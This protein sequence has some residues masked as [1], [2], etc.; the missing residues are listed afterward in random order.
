[1]IPQG[2]QHQEATLAAAEKSH[3]CCCTQHQAES[4]HS[5]QRATDLSGW[6]RKPPP[7]ELSCSGREGNSFT[8]KT[9][10][11]AS[12]NPNN[13]YAF[14]R[15]DLQKDRTN[16]LN[17]KMHGWKHHLSMTFHSVNTGQRAWEGLTLRPHQ[18]PLMDSSHFAFQHFFASLLSAECLGPAPELPHW[19]SWKHKE[20]KRDHLLFFHYS[21]SSPFSFQC[22]FSYCPISLQWQPPKNSINCVSPYLPLSHCQESIQYYLP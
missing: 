16:I 8:V 4:I 5:L 3:G 15:E 10:H 19:S 2:R 17:R 6:G 11:R 21:F 22:Q 12:Q 18:Q 7:W 13:V 1:M 14:P 9:N 20:A